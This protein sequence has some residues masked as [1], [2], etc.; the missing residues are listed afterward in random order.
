M[1]GTL[2]STV[3]HPPCSAPEVDR[4]RIPSIVKAEVI[5]NFARV[6]VVYHVNRA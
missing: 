2:K 1:H 6:G 4:T 3:T 5:V